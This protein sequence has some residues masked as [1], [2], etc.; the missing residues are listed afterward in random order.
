MSS[1]YDC[2]KVLSSSSQGLSPLPG[3]N[4]ALHFSQ[5]PWRLEN[6]EGLYL[7][8]IVTASCHPLWYLQGLPSAHSIPLLSKTI[9]NHLG[10]REFLQRMFQVSSKMGHSAMEGVKTDKKKSSLPFW[11][12][13]KVYS[14]FQMEQLNSGIRLGKRNVPVR[15]QRI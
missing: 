9:L 7:C 8:G 14:L 6:G 15:C 4:L 1:F 11:F 3:V 5:L 13:R 10:K 2:H 12:W